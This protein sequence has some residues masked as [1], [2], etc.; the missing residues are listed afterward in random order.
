MLQRMKLTDPNFQI[1]KKERIWC[2]R[3]AKRSTDPVQTFNQHIQKG[4]IYRCISCHR[5]RYR[6]S[7]VPFVQSQYRAAC[8]L[9]LTSMMM[10]FSK[11]NDD[12]LYICKTCESKVTDGKLPAQAAIN[13]LQLDD[14]PAPLHLTELES[15][16]IAQCV[17]FMKLLALLR[18]R[19]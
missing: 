13:G 18:G 16:L 11:C 8:Q 19:Q 10:V 9:M 3:Q 15:V 5:H 14:V 2:V 7:A 4:Q 1:H 6:Q 17:P 12:Q